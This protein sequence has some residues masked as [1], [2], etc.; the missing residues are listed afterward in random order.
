MSFYDYAR[1]WFIEHLERDIAAH[2]TG[3]YDEIG[4][5]E[6][7]SPEWNLIEDETQSHRLGLAANF[8]NMWMDSRNHGWWHYPGMNEGDWP[9]V[10]R[11]IVCG[12][13]ENWEP[14]RMRENAVFDPP[15]LPPRASLWRRWRRALGEP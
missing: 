14:E 7:G 8:W 2:E 10:A 15:L 1:D 5:S 4:V 12:L 13:R 9:V 11:Q 6:E 3:R